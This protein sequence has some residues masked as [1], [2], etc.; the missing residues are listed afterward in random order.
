MPLGTR[1]AS[2]PYYPRSIETF[3]ARDGPM[4]RGYGGPAVQCERHD[5][6]RHDTTRHDTTRHAAPHDL[7]LF[8]RRRIR[9]RGFSPRPG[10]K[11][12]NLFLTPLLTPGQN[13]MVM[14]APLCSTSHKG[15][16]VSC[17]GGD[18]SRRGLGSET[19]R[20]QWAPPSDAGWSRLWRWVRLGPYGEYIP[21]VGAVVVSRNY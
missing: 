9:D 15:G 3:S 16:V 7:G 12:S 17:A 2:H 8:M 18:G 20:V 11:G 13:A 4:G 6:T 21:Q 19:G 10:R 1:V 14:V 5:T